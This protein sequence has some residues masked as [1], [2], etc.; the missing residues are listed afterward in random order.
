[1]IFILTFLLIIVANY[2][3]SINN[4][5]IYKKLKIEFLK[6]IIDKN[7]NISIINQVCKHHTKNHCFI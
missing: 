3:E 6:P 7:F 4:K 2:V 1:M 5:D